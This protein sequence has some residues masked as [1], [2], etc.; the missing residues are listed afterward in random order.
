M[1]QGLKTGPVNIF[2]RDPKAKGLPVLLETRK[3]PGLKTVMTNNFGFAGTNA[4][5]V[6]QR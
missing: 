5:L 2:E 1:D 3:A 6:F 4:S